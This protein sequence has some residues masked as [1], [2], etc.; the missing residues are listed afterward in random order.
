MKTVSFSGERGATYLL[1]GIRQSSVGTRG[2]RAAWGRLGLQRIP[3]SIPLKWTHR[4]PP[5]PIV[6]GAGERA[7]NPTRR[8]QARVLAGRPDP[9]AL[10]RWRAP[11][12][13]YLG[14]TG[15]L[16]RKGD[17]LSGSIERRLLVRLPLE[18]RQLQLVSGRRGPGP[19]HG[20]QRRTK[21][22]G[23]QAAHTPP[24]GAES[25]AASRVARSLPP[26]MGGGAE[27]GR[28]RAAG[29]AMGR[30]GLFFWFVQGTA[31]APF[32][33]PVDMKQEGPAGCRL[34][35]G[36]PGSAV[37][38]EKVGIPPPGAV[39]FWDLTQLSPPSISSFIS[40]TNNLAASCE[41]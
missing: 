19:F 18:H 11:M 13:P 6:G 35:Q 24:Q 10:R 7:G 1:R 27:R 4:A 28:P 29:G 30:G 2:Q 31:C 25:K 16:G 12:R 34:W 8:S 39:C 20:R 22:A 9:S 40:S 26:W 15:L 14:W 21:P 38:W 37:P 32:P 23:E 5:A 3:G 41:F 33:V 36:R 17:D